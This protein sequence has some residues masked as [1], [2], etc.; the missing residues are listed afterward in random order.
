MTSGELPTKCYLGSSFL[1]LI[2]FSF[3]P[4]AHLGRTPACSQQQETLAHPAVTHGSPEAPGLHLKWAQNASLV[5]SAKSLSSKEIKTPQTLNISSY[6]EAVGVGTSDT[7]AAQSAFC[8]FLQSFT[9]QHL[10]THSI[11]LP[12]RGLVLQRQ[13]PSSPQLTAS[14]APPAQQLWEK[15]KGNEW[16]STTCNSCT[17][18]LH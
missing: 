7:A 3:L 10:A 15:K 13:A 2:L 17:F 1:L 5:H 9:V 18:A 16:E 11:P 6:R 14:P 4:R 8:P 12:V